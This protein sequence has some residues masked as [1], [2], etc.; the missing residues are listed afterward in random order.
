MGAA[1][2][3]SGYPPTGDWEAWLRF[4]LEGVREVAEAAAKTARTAS[5]AIREITGRQRARV[6]TYERYLA[7]LRE[8][9]EDPK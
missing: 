3:G 9:T 8:G 4:F 5:E 6:Y 2:T 7:V 1:S